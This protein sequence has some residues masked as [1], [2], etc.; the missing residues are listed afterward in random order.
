MAKRMIRAVAVVVALLLAAPGG[1]TDPVVVVGDR[2][3]EVAAVP[4]SGADTFSL[5]YR[6]SIYERP[7]VETF[8]VDAGGGFDLVRV[9]SPSEEVLDYYGIEGKRV[10]RGAWRRLVLEQPQ[11][12]SELSLIATPTGRRTLLVGD[13][14]IPLYGARSPVHL[15]IWVRPGLQE[16]PEG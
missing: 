15:S 6:H 11:R 13:R 8:A 10:S 3:G 5:R 4:L 1:G 16:A 2:N 12:F 9:S 14:S 7:A